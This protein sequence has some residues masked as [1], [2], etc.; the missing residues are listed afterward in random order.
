MR[1]ADLETAQPSR[2]DTIGN[3][4]QAQRDPNTGQA[5]TQTYYGNGLNQYYQVQAQGGGSPL[6]QG[7]RSGRDTP[8]E[9]QNANG[10]ARAISPTGLRS[11]GISRSRSSGDSSAGSPGWPTAIIASMS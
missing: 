10:P 4:Q 5:V 3:R 11:V 7:L 8:A 2:C 6:S 9:S 1:R